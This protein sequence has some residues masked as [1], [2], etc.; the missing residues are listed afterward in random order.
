MLPVC[1]LNSAYV[2]ASHEILSGSDLDNY[3]FAKQR[4]ALTEMSTG[5]ISW[6]VKAAGL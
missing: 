3:L 2:S 6:G 4:I 1:R 5:N